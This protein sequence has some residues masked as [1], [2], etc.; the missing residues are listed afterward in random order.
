V[1]YLL[2]QWGSP[3]N[4]G[5]VKAIPTVGES[6]ATYNVVGIALTSASS[7]GDVIEFVS[8]VPQLHVV[9]AS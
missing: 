7:D 4:R 6:D 2:A 8:C 3:I 9:V 1:R 5:M